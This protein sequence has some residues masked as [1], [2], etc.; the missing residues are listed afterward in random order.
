MGFLPLQPHGV[1]VEAAGTGG[2]KRFTARLRLDTPTEADC[3]RHG[4]I[5]PDALRV[6]LPT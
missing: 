1:T 4:G 2:T 6:R 3:C 5:L